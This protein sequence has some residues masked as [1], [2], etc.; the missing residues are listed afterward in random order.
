M[1]NYV[2]CDIIKDDS[3]ENTLIREVISMTTSFREMASNKSY[4]EVEC[5]LRIHN[6][7][8]QNSG[9]RALV[10]AIMA[11]LKNS[12]LEL[13]Q[14]LEI[15]FRN[16]VG[17]VL[18]KEICFLQM[19][20]CVQDVYTF[21]T[22]E[23]EDDNIVFKFIKTIS[24]E[25]RMKDSIRMRLLSS[26]I[27]LGEKQISEIIKIA[28]RRL[29]KPE[30]TFWEILNHVAGVEGFIEVQDLIFDI[31]PII[32]S[33]NIKQIIEDK[34]KDIYSPKERA[35]KKRELLEPYCKEIEDLINDLN[36]NYLNLQF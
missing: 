26:D 35:F 20:E 10:S 32:S 19:K 21:E 2:K 31:Y 24:A 5:L 16:S 3:N 30:D 12:D 11:Y 18:N 25:V 15:G 8:Q 6:V 13:E 4:S 27:E 29:M 22:E 28:I 7:D 1:K 36:K 17:R 23:V 34:T 33:I 9:F 14:L